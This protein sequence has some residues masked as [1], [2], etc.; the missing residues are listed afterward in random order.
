LARLREE[1]RQFTSRGAEILAVGPNDADTF[2][3]YWVDEK[4]PFVGLPD[5][6]HAVARMYRQEVNLF[7]LGRMPL[8]CVLDAQGY[9]RFA[10]YGASMRDIPS[11]QELWQVI[12]ELKASSN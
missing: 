9:V 8:N 7:K 12:D 5:P 11:N 3:R 10:H 4:I 1:Y 6:D 2:K